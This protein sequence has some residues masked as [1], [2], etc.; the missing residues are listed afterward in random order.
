MNGTKYICSSVYI[1][2]RTKDNAGRAVYR[3]VR[4]KQLGA[5][6]ALSRFAGRALLFAT[7]LALAGTGCLL[8][9]AKLPCFICRVFGSLT[10]LSSLRKGLAKKPFDQPLTTVHLELEVR[11]L[12]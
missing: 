7:R 6:G 11:E 3:S 5:R 4:V 9:M 1:I 2:I 10:T 12:V 8:L